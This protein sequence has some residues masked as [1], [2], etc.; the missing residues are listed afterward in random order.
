MKTGVLN[1]RERM[2]LTM[3][4]KETDYIPC[5]FM[6]FHGLRDRFPNNQIKFIEEQIKLGLDTVVEFPEFPI[7]FHP[8]VTM[9][10]WKENSDKIPYPLL[11]KEYYTPAGTLKTVVKKTEDWPCGDKV[12]FYN[13]HNVPRSLRFHVNERADLK[14]FRYLLMPPTASEIK[15]YREQCAILR[16]FADRKGL[17]TRGVRGVLVDAAIRFA[18]VENLIF[19]AIEDPEYIEELLDIISNWN[20]QRMEIV[21]EQ[22]PDMFLRRAWYENMS[23]WSPQMYRKFMKPYLEKEVKW[24]HSQGVKF[25]YINTCS[26]MN[27]LKDFLSVGFDVLIGVDPVQDTELDMMKLKQKLS[28][29]ISLWGG[30]N[31]FVTIE[32][33]TH[34]E[35]RTEVEN[36]INILSPGGG[37]ILSPVDNVRDTSEKALRNAKVF[38]KTWDKLKYL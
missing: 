22:K 36:S 16:K 10:T 35:I 31:G 25:G 11:N 13:D 38:I 14:S 26:Y 37:F 20:M 29:K 19:A 28:G 24:A 4:Y 3:E 12:A 23:F 7:K 18:G 2:L 6:M 17:M 8:E 30:G 27:I 5:S 9:K 1:S 32:Q 15:E 34:E 33:G 21:L